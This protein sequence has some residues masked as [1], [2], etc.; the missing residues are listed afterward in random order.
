[1]DS[2]VMAAACRG[3]RLPVGIMR[4]SHMLTMH[5]KAI[6]LFS[7][8]AGPEEHPLLNTMGKKNQ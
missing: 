3:L 8:R 1:M 2:I 7:L 4:L 5:S 6:P